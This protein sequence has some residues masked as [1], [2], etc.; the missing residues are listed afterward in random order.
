MDG[1]VR[2]S[3]RPFL[4]SEWYAQSLDSADTKATGAGF[5]VKSQRDRGLFYQ[6]LALG[7]L[8][9]PDCLGWHWFKYGG[10]G[11]GY[12]KGIVDTQYRPHEDLL[13]VMQ[14]LNEQVYPLAGQLSKRRA[15][16]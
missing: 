9:H 13:S 14:E 11:P 5:R 2:A 12:S 1:W 8:E 15:P 3:G 16:N 10:D 4:V 7:L 6:N